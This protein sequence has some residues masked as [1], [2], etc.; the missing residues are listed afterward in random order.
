MLY[1]IK[2]EEISLIFIDSIHSYTHTHYIISF[3]YYNIRNNLITEHCVI[4]MQKDW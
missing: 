2:K 3:V 4:Y 1:I